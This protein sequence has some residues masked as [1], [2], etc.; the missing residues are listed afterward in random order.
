MVDLIARKRIHRT[1]PGESLR[2]QAHIARVLV[3]IGHAVYAPPPAPLVEMVKEPAK[4]KPVP[5][6]RKGQ[7]AR[8]DMV[9]EPSAKLFFAPDPPRYPAPSVEQI[10]TKDPVGDVEA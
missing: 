2:V 7:Y 4:A 6:A 9:A 1:K 8:R 10:V 3:A 5:P